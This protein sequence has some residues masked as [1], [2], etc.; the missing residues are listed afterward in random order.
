MHASYFPFKSI[1]YL[2]FRKTNGKNKFSALISLLPLGKFHTLISLFLKEEIQMSGNLC[3]AWKPCYPPFPCFQVNKSFWYSYDFIARHQ[4]FFQ[5]KQ[6]TALF[7]T[8]GILWPALPKSRKVTK[9]VHKMSKENNP[10]NLHVEPLAP[11]QNQPS[12]ICKG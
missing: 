7:A 1:Q 10:G 4:V 3:I 6:V 2:L 9:M 12:L 5:F 8:S 11:K